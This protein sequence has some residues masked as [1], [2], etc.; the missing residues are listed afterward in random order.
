MVNDDAVDP[1]RKRWLVFSSAYVMIFIIASIAICSVFSAPMTQ[2]RGWSLSDYNLA[3]SISTLSQCITAVGAGWYMTRHRVKYMM[4]PG[5]LLIGAGWFLSSFATSVPQFYLT[6]GL[7][8]G[9]G[10]GMLYNPSLITALKWFP[11]RTGKISGLLLSSAA[12]GPFLLAPIAAGLIDAF[13]VLNAY[14]ILGILF[15]V[16]SFS[17]A[18]WLNEASKNDLSRPLRKKSRADGLNW[19]GMLKQP[20]F[21]ALIATFTVAST[22]GTMLVSSVSVIA[23]HQV[24]FS[25][26]AGAVVVS[27]STLANFFGRVAFGFIYERI[28]AIKSLCLDLSLTMVA[29]LLLTTIAAP[30]P[31]VFCIVVLGFAFGGLL[32]IF[33]PMTGRMFGTKYLGMNYS[34]VFLGYAGGA[35][36]GPRIAAYFHET[37]GAFNAAYVAAA[38]L[39][40]GGLVLAALIAAGRRRRPHAV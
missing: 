19:R 7:M 32:V 26:A 13:G 34:L 9:A 17:T 12:I 16:L 1:E 31:F 30:V 20:A 39:T 25:A 2:L 4:Y 14:R 21:Y 11:D 3:Y 28:G 33:P 35:L 6:F 15:I 38:V 23:Q 37:T 40:A 36:I 22:A 8:A 10:S 18:Q 24:G 29:L 27:I 5:G